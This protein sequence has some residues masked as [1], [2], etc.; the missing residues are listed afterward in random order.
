MLSGAASVIVLP[1]VYVATPIVLGP[2][3]GQVPLLLLLL[4]PNVLC[5]AAVRPLY[6]FFQV[7][8][9][10]PS[11][12][13]RVV[14][15]ALVVNTVLNIAI[16]PLWG[17]TGAALAA[18]VSGLVAVAVAFPA[19]LHLAGV[20]LAEFR[21]RRSDLDPYVSLAGSLLRRGA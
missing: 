14:A 13:Y 18:S 15:A 10:K 2:G 17:A 3:Y 20:R 4:T 19:F 9:Q 7:Q 12:L 1:V 11:S 6:G 5:L 8:A 16:V 21:P